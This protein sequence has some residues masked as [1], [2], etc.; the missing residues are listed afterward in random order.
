MWNHFGSKTYICVQLWGLAFQKITPTHYLIYS[1]LTFYSTS[2]RDLFHFAEILASSAGFLIIYVIL[3]QLFNKAICTESSL[4]LLVTIFTSWCTHSR[5]RFDSLLQS[6]HLFDLIASIQ[7][8]DLYW[9]LNWTDGHF[10]TSWFCTNSTSINSSQCNL[11]ICNLACAEQLHFCISLHASIEDMDDGW[12]L[13]PGDMNPVRQIGFWT[14]LKSI[15]PA[16][17]KV[18]FKCECSARL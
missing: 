1:V 11:V 3:S 5:S 7:H 12:D 13:S 17:E 14:K 18:I 2:F 4:D 9:F 16:R 15:I 10:L 6:G 8:C